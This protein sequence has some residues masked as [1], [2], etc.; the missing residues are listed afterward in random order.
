MFGGSSE[1][2]PPRVELGV[3]GAAVE[4]TA[5]T[6]A[7]PK[8]QRKLL[9]TPSRNVASGRV[10]CLP[11]WTSAFRRSAIASRSTSRIIDRSLCANNGEATT[12]PGISV[13]FEARE[14]PDDRRESTE[15]A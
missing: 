9:K 10:A 14:A 15:I 7:S 13:G 3:G 4:S 2:A 1:F 8:V 6:S 11:L 12:R 5:L